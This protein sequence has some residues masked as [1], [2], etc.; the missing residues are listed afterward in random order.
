M[1]RSL[2]VRLRLRRTSVFLA[3][4]AY[5]FSVSAQS[6]PPT[7]G[8]IWH[9]P[10]E[11][12]LSA[13][14]S[15][16]GGNS[17]ALN[18]TKVYSLAELIDIAE[19]N[20]PETRIVW[21]R[22]KQEADRLG[23]AR[24]QWYPLV[25]AS[26]LGLDGR[27]AV[28]IGPDFERQ[29]V[30]YVQPTLSLFY[31][32]LDFGNRRAQVNTAAQTLLAADFVFNDTHTRIIFTVSAAYYQLIGAQGETQAAEAA[33]LNS[34][35]VQDATQDRY[36]RGLATLPNVLQ[37]K[38]ATAQARYEVAAVRGREKLAHAKLT[39]ALGVAP[40]VPLVVLGL[41][42][43]APPEMLRESVESAI[44]RALHQ[45]PDLLSQMAIVHA[46]EQDI[47]RARSYYL[48]T[49]GFSGTADYQYIWGLREGSIPGTAAQGATWLAQLG[50]RWT[51]FD[52][53]ARYNELDRAKSANREAKAQLE[54]LRNQVETDVW[55]AYSNTETALQQQEAASALL[56]AAEQSYSAA[57]DSYQSGVQD[58]LDV[59]S[60]QRALAQAR[61][62]QVSARTLVLTD[63]ADLLFRTG[64]LLRT[65]PAARRT[66]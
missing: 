15:T 31:T 51:L 38:A 11:S 18:A 29:D 4:L 59:L 27:N 20:N 44:Q 34:Q 1:R 46:T 55:I 3:Y 45:R 33:L 19:Q 65:T 66:F 6:P 47:K 32:L 35:A 52:G 9:A 23:L 22:A 60:A 17:P 28:L 13:E 40:T 5:S 39:Q 8:A 14:L 2:P 63:I 24:A 30:A 25:V 26:V 12:S 41:Q 10:D 42:D 57:L 7:P 43:N 21:E 49:V 61:S 53:R 54:S 16:V 64:D 48:P 56:T 50:A 37:A 36:D 58:F 62:S